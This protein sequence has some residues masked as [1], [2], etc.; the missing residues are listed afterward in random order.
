M[1]AV[2]GRGVNEIRMG[3]LQTNMTGLFYLS[4]V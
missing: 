1:V 4:G 2:A 3:R